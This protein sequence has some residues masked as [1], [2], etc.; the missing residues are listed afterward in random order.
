MRPGIAGY[1]L[2]MESPAGGYTDPGFERSQNTWVATVA[3]AV[4]RHEMSEVSMPHGLEG[5]DAHR[6][7]GPRRSA[8][9][10]QT[11]DPGSA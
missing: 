8:R 6:E 10:S 5:D 11:V 1:G 9:M 4:A 2:R 7:R 3:S